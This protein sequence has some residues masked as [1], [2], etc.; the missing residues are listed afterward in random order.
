V[1]LVSAAVPQA[2]KLLGKFVLTSGYAGG[3][4]ILLLPLIEREKSREISPFEK[5]ARLSN[6]AVPQ[7]P[8]KRLVQASDP[9]DP[10]L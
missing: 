3:P 4:T 9:E 8:A 1:Y 7:V 2:K 10:H 6:Y 5:F